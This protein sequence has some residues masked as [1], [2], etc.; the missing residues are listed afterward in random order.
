MKDC[1]RCG[2]SYAKLNSHLSNN[3][4]CEVKFLDITNWEM[5]NNYNIHLKDYLQLKENLDNN[6]ACQFCKKNFSKR[7]N[8]TRHEKVCKLNIENSAIIDSTVYSHNNV[9]ITNNF[10]FNVNNF[11]EEKLMH[12]TDLVTLL[13]D[14]TIDLLPTYIEKNWV[15][16]EENRNVHLRN[17]EMMANGM[18]EVY[19]DGWKF[20]L[21]KEVIDKMREKSTK[22]IRIVLREI[23]EETVNN[24][25]E[26]GREQERLKKISR[27]KKY[28]DEIEK[29]PEK[30]NDVDLKIKCVL[31]NNKDKIEKSR[32]AH[33]QREEFKSF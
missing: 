16:N 13:N 30:R 31:I 26:E 12:V 6:K 1:L 5:K 14:K 32:N 3:K 18:V 29:I 8:C 28:L 24:E 7:K 20:E 17:E 2:N 9:N 21:L 33:K 4:Q 10:N 25:W 27:I 19:N 23:Y 15:D 22:N 11:G